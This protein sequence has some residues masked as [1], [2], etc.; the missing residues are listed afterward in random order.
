MDKIVINAAERN[1]K[2]NKVRSQGFI[3]GVIFGKGIE[4]KSVKIE[5]KELAKVQHGHLR[6]ARLQVKLGEEVKHC[7]VKEIQKDPV[8]GNVIHFNLQSIHDNDIIKLRVPL[9][10]TGKEKLQGKQLLLEENLTEVE[11]SGKASILPEVI[12]IDVSNL[13]H[14]DKIALKDIPVRDGIKVLGNEDELAAVVTYAREVPEE[15]EDTEAEA[16]KK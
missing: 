8:K 15:A 11:I 14:E 7:I 2:P 4:S 9:I 3:P 10:F 6:N 12:S 1:E 13:K 16:E 5:E